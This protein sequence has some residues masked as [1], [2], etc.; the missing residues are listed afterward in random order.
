MTAPNPSQ[1]PSTAV[2]APTWPPLLVVPALGVIGLGVLLPAWVL[3]VALSTGIAFSWCESRLG[4]LGI[5]SG[6]TLLVAVLAGLLIVIGGLGAA[7][8]GTLQD[9]LRTRAPAD[10]A[11]KP[12]NLRQWFWDHPWWALGAALLVADILLI[13]GSGHRAA[14]PRNAAI[15]ILATTSWSILTAAW[16]FYRLA[17]ATLRLGWRLSRS[18]SAVA[19]LVV[20]AGVATATGWAVL[21]EIADLITQPEFV[22]ELK[23]R[24]ADGRGFSSWRGGLGAP[25]GAA[26]PA[27]LFEHEQLGALLRAPVYLGDP[28]DSPFD[29]L[30]P[31]TFAACAEQLDSRLRMEATWHAARY[32]GTTD[33]EDVVQDILVRVCL[34]RQPPREFRSFF[35][36]AVQNRASTWRSRAARNCPLY[37][38]PEP[39][40]DIREDE[41]YL[42]LE[43]L[44]AANDA[45]CTLT[46]SEQDILRLRYYE[47]KDYAEIAVAMGITQVNAR[48]RVSRAIAKLRAEFQRLC[49]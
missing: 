14:F 22:E 15:A 49:R 19:A 25:G 8:W 2:T 44:R 43:T 28:G 3:A 24:R 42:R 6:E 11:A 18:S 41:E 16:L 23:R 17:W 7:A 10:Q 31:D 20:V 26:V 46:E 33:A 13:P 37:A 4:R 1:P 48:Q 47:R 39:S 38:V 45:L 32:V 30:L 12:R 34:R 40:C 29:G 21:V 35:I 9:S 36:K 5:R 27:A